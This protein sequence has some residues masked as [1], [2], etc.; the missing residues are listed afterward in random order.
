MSTRNKVLLRGR[1]TRNAETKVLSSG[2]NIANFSVACNRFKKDADGKW[3]EEVDFI[4]N[5]SLYGN[6][7][8]G[9]APYLVQGQLVA[10]EGHLIQRRWEKDGKKMHRLE[11]CIDDIELLGGKPKDKSGVAPID[12]TPLDANMF[13]NEMPPEEEMSEPKFEEEVF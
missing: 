1:L 13:E 10:I 12:T 3:S 5:L 8:S 2:L 11:V 9:L 6:R 7:A 4:D